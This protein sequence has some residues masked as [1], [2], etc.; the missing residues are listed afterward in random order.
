MK[1]HENE[2]VRAGIGFVAWLVFVA[3]F[4]LWPPMYVVRVF[5]AVI[6][7][8]CGVF[9]SLGITLMVVV[10]I[11]AAI[12]TVFYGGGDSRPV[13]DRVLDKFKN[14]MDFIT[15]PSAWAARLRREPSP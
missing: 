2:S 7:G 8:A 9:Y 5:F 15:S 4:N 12:H 11:G 13:Y 14:A 6:F 1:W 10:W 3:L